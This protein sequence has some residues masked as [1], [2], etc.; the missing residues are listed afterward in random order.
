MNLLL[1]RFKKS[2][3][4]EQDAVELAEKEDDTNRIQWGHLDLSNLYLKSGYPEKALEECEKLRGLLVEG[5]NQRNA[6]YWKS[7]AYL[8]MGSTDKARQTAEEL[9]EIINKGINKKNMR[10]YYH[11][12][13]LIE[14]ERGQYSQAIDFFTKALPL[15]F[16]A[17]EWHIIIADAL[18]TA[19]FKA[20]SLEKSR[21]EY[22]K[23]I[24]PIPGRVWHGDIYAKSFYMLGKIYE[25]LGD[26]AKAV[27]HYEKFLDLWKDADPGKV[28]VEDARKRL[29]GLKKQ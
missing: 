22:E 26:S 19:Y 12:M 25:Q 3:D 11:L 9:K 5:S 29:A 20:G 13:G 15:L 28:E 23:I 10:M 27:E 17:S 24:S 4:L 2:I 16:L 8:A 14:L 21:E 7:Q 18:G 1:G 6:Q